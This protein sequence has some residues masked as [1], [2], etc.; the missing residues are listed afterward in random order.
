MEY[1]EDFNKGP[2]VKGSDGN[3]YVWGYNGAGCLGETTSNV[4]DTPEVFTL[5]NG[6][7]PVA[8]SRG[9]EHTL[10]IGD[11]GELYVCGENTNGQLGLGL[12]FDFN[13]KVKT[14]T[15][16]TLPENSKPVLISA[17]RYNSFVLADNG[18]LYSWGV[19]SCGTLG[20]GDKINRN[21]PQEVILPDGFKPT[22]IM[23][24]NG[25]AILIDKDLNMYGAGYATGV[26]CIVTGEYNTD[27]VEFRKIENPIIE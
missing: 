22:K 26:S 23:A 17:G 9:E 14:P 3:F 24:G 27:C 10:S 2:F 11:D 20:L 25:T 1:I 7:K 8:L 6:V 15:K 13:V 16:I 18:K 21:T 4:V 5:P 19:N 12:E